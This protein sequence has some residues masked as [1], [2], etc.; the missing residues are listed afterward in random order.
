MRGLPGIEDLKAS[1]VTAGESL[2][3]FAGVSL[4]NRWRMYLSPQLLLAL[5][6]ANPAIVILRSYSNL[7][8][9]TAPVQV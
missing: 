2:S 4:F 1:G 7:L 8:L 5:V 3:T 6:V 9:H